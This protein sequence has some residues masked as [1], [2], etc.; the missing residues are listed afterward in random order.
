V[1][2]ATGLLLGLVA[3]MISLLTAV[4]AASIE[5]MAVLRNE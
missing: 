4:R 1:I 5:P 3:T 2:L